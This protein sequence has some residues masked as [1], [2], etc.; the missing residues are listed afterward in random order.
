MTARVIVFHSLDHARAALAAAA[1]RGVPVTL[2]SAPGA[3]AYAGAG[4]LKAIV[5]AAAAENPDV[6]V[7]AVIDCGADAGAAMGALR[8]GW[9][10]ILFSGRDDVA[11]RLAD[12]AREAG[13]RL[14]GEGPEALD[15]LDAADP[16]A[17]CRAFLGG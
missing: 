4:Y 1:Q 13:A 7:S 14:T 3:V 12:M 16:A 2:R 9:R 15:L 10:A 11:A 17:L 8:A 6:A 5:D